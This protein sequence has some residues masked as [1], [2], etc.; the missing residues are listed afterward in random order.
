M[1][2]VLCR[3]QGAID[4]ALPT[5]DGWI[6]CVILGDRMDVI[7]FQLCGIIYC[8]PACDTFSVALIYHLLRLLASRQEDMSVKT[9]QSF[10]NTCKQSNGVGA[11]VA[12]AVAATK[13]REA[14][15]RLRALP[16]PP[17]SHSFLCTPLTGCRCTLFNDVNTFIHLRR[18]AVYCRPPFVS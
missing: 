7:F 4:E 14:Q 8:S 17:P 1:T 3:I 13:V 2:N 18:P 10:A 11:T 6:V 12:T 16:S 5:R 15:A 9:F